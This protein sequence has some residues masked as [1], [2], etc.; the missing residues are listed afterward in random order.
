VT[1]NADEQARSQQMESSPKILL[2][3]EDDDQKESLHHP[4]RKQILRVLSAGIHDYETEVT[5]NVRTLEDG[6]GLTH[7]VEVRR[8]IQ[9]YWMAVPEIVERLKQRYPEHGITSYQCYYHLQKLEEQGLVEQDPP[10]EFEDNG[11]KKRT[12]GIQFRSAA[13]FFIY[14]K[15]GFSV[16]GTNPCL[17]FLQK[18]WG[19]DPS[20]KDCEELAQLVAEQDQTLFKTLEN[21]VKHMD[22][23][24]V[25]SVSFSI[26]LDRLAHVF[27]S[28]DDEFIERYRDAKRI[29]VR[30]GGERLVSDEAQSSGTEDVKEEETRGKNDE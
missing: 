11:R 17:E 12:R 2:L 18:G 25:D 6:T 15:P 1:I 7:S 14:H 5:T 27:L 9:R 3:I 21:L 20:E 28:D 13:R 10:S 4:I 8:P 26:L 22:G 23:S 29:L 30:S 24:A 16:D 19:L